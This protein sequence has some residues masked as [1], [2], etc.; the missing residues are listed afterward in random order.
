MYRKLPKLLVTA[1]NIQC[2]LIFPH[3]KKKPLSVFLNVL[4]TNGIRCHRISRKTKTNILITMT[5]FKTDKT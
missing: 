1:M 3:S 2:L 4:S 5:N